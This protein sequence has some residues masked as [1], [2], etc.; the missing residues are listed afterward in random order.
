MSTPTK[1]VK[2]FMKHHERTVI[3][4][5]WSQ[6]LWMEVNC[7]KHK[8]MAFSFPPSDAM[9]LRSVFSEDT[10]RDLAKGVLL[11]KVHQ[12]EARHLGEYMLTHIGQLRLLK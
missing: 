5:C 12:T 2:K 8:V 10:Q 7:L 3:G 4:P 1:G 6:H 11:L 9:A